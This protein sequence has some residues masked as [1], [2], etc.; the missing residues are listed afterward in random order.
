[1]DE[2]RLQRYRKKLAFIVDSLAYVNPFG[3]D[4]LQNRGVLYSIR[5]AIEGMV[6]IVAML[7]KDLG[8]IVEEDSKNI[9]KLIQH[10]KWEQKPGDDLIH[11]NGLRNIIVHQYNG[12]EEK[13]VVN[14][15]PEVKRVITL[16]LE[17]SEEVL[18]ELTH[19]N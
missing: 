10:Q 11:A 4:K 17:L 16:W 15:I 5:T 14:S 2:L 6:D 13:I 7:V 18:N 1:M 3:S 12:I 19:I 8:M 9:L